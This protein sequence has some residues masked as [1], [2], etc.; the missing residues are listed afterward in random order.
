MAT[1]PVGQRTLDKYGEQICEL[2]RK[3]IRDPEIAITVGLSRP[4][5]MRV[6]QYFQVTAVKGRPTVAE[7]R[8]RKRSYLK[9]ESDTTQE[10]VNLCLKCRQPMES[11]H[12][13]HRICDPCKSGSDWQTEVHTTYVNHSLIAGG[14][15]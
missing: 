4:V 13:G 11:E 5:V 3:G 14:G 2:A 1:S 6:R 15:K 12:F 9:P 7:R 10:K 8:K